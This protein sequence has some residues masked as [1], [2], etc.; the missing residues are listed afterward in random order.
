MAYE[1]LL[2]RRLHRWNQTILLVGRTSRPLRPGDDLVTFRAGGVGEE[3][4]RWPA[5]WRSLYADRVHHAPAVGTDVVES[6]DRGPIFGWSAARS[7]F[8]APKVSD[9]IPSK[10]STRGGAVTL[11]GSNLGG[12]QAS[13]WLDGA[14]LSIVLAGHDAIEVE[15]PA[16]VGMGRELQVVHSGVVGQEGLRDAISFSYER[17]RIDS[18]L[19]RP[20]DVS[21]EYA[22]RWVLTLEIIGEN[23]GRPLRAISP[24]TSRLAT[25]DPARCRKSSN[26]ATAEW[27]QTAASMRKPASSRGQST[28]W[29]PWAWACSPGA[30]LASVGESTAMAR[31]TRNACTATAD[32]DP[33]EH[34][35]RV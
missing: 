11:S 27:S 23:F 35:T 33:C 31:D 3:T 14:P 6:D 22:L 24:E 8:A 1:A 17:P 20:F 4:K 25:G 5:P 30:R 19:P 16:S 29:E 10:P 9:L 34:E 12:E 26:G 21:S 28:D 2:R 7:W 18:V 32:C 13:V 15:L